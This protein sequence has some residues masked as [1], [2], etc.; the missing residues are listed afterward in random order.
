V[1]VKAV[2]NLKGK[3]LGGSGGDRRFV[4]LDGGG[5]G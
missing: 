2:T 4:D 3:K 1:E 5:W